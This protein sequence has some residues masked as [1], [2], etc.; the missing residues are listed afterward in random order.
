MKNLRNDVR[1]VLINFIINKCIV[2]RVLPGVER[3]WQCNCDGWLQLLRSSAAAIFI[4]SLVACVMRMWVR[5]PIIAK[6][7][8]MLGLQ[9][10][11]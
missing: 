1:W 9:E 5:A 3:K 7:R 10:V 4:L 2:G 6:V 11:A 8:C